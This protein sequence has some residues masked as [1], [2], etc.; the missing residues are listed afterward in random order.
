MTKGFMTDANPQPQDMFKNIVQIGVVVANLDETTKALSE[1]FG[2]GPFRTIYW[3]PAGR[4]DIQ[5]YY[6]GQPATFTAR[7][8]FAEIG[9]LELEL[10]EPLAGESAWA[11]F[12]KERG[13]G[14]HHILFNTLDLKPVLDHL[15]RH[16]INPTQSGS[17]I[18]LG[19]IWT[20]FRSPDIGGVIFGDFQR[21]EPI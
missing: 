2:I 17:G 16:G 3:P 14:I 10:I 18:R 1:I 7:M 19:T 9:S 6:H 11:D 13:P 8:A 20:N 12:L 21:A 15:A 4:T 5:R